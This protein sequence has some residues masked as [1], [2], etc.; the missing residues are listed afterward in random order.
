MPDSV[1]QTRIADPWPKVGKDEELFMNILELIYTV[2]QQP[3][4]IMCTLLSDPARH[5]RVLLSLT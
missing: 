1:L 2:K 5:R 3:H 4:A